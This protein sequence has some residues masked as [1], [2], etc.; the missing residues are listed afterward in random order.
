M[1]YKLLE[2]HC[3]NYKNGGSPSGSTEIPTDIKL[4]EIQT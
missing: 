2:G 4:I 1:F 3:L